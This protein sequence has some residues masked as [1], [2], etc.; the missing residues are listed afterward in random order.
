M[1]SNTGQQGQ[2]QART[3]LKG[4]FHPPEIFI[5]V[6]LRVAKN[7]ADMLHAKSSLGALSTHKT[8]YVQGLNAILAL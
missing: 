3:V 4:F 6:F 8:N 7:S 5:N 2:N 1:G